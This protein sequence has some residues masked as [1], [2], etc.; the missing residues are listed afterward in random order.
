MLKLWLGTYA[1]SGGRGL[2]PLSVATDGT[3]AAGDPFAAAANASFG[4]RGNGLAYFVDEQDDGALTVIEASEGGWRGLA[5]VATL[6]GAPCH[7]ALDRSGGRLAVANYASG[8]VALYALGSDGLPLGPPALFQG[9][10]SGPVADRQDGPH[11]HCV[12]F[13]RGG[14]GLYWVDLG[15]DRV[16]CLKL[17]KG[18]VFLDAVTAWRAP[19]G[20]G[21]RHLLFHPNRPLALLLSELASTLTV[22]QLRDGTLHP[23]QA[24]STL[25]AGFRGESLGGHLELNAAGNRLYA[26]NRGHDSLAVFA[27][28]SGRLELVQHIA[29]GGAHPRHFV[30]AEEHGVLAVAHERDGR[31][32]VFALAPDGTLAP[33]GPGATVA[34]ACFLLR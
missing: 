32:A 11:A 30:L 6:G 20:S 22:L 12:R 29:S 9:S 34:G 2:V 27:L 4:V 16:E 31:V 10:G 23:H 28:E 21:P 33:R 7:L 3:I 14:E 25:L 24:I 8:T 17:G 18:A 26:S 13:S 19:P 15:A 5:R 1:K